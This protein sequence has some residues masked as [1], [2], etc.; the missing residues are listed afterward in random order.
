MVEQGSLL[1]SNEKPVAWVRDAQIDRIDEADAFVNFPQKQCTG[2][3]GET[4]AVEVSL[5]FFGI[6]T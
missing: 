4:S 3:R 2:I 5:N 1:V 6:E